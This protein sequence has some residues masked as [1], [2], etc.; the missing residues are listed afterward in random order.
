MLSREQMETYCKKH[1][2]DIFKYCMYK[3]NNKEDAEDATQETFFVFSKKGHLVDEEHVR[4]WLFITAKYVVYRMYRNRKNELSR[5]TEFNE[6][7][8]ELVRSFHSFEQDVIDLYSDRFIEYIYPRLTEK[9]K[10]LYE[11]YSEGTMKTA[12]MARILGIEP[13]NCSM[14]KKRLRERFRELMLEIM[15]Y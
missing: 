10:E 8:P 9:E 4:P 5:T 7:M 12:E 15:F 2:G 13:H 1:Y 6:D 3:L 11:L 14:R